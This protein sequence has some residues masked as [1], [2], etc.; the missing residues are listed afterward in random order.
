MGMYASN[1]LV[2]AP[3]VH[4]TVRFT[5]TQPKIQTLHV[6]SSLILRYM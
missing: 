4:F 5:P 6:L 1:V 3:R 2:V